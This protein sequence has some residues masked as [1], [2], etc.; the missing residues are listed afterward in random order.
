MNKARDEDAE[1]LIKNDPVRPELS[2]PGS[3]ELSAAFR[4]S[5]AREMYYLG[6]VDQPEAV[7]CIAIC[8][9][10]PTTVAQLEASGEGDIAVIYTVWSYPTAPRAGAQLLVQVWN[11]LRE[12]GTC[13]RY[14][15]LSPKTEMASKLHTQNGAS[16]LANNEETDNFEYLG[17]PMI[18]AGDACPTFTLQ[19]DTGATVELSDLWC[20]GVP[21]DLG[22][23]FFLFPKANI[24]LGLIVALHYRSSASH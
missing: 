15:A 12:K 18:R 23:V 11:M 17:V 2:A 5:G 21:Q 13:A 3:S 6:T 16:L 7:I 24:G 20:S 8:D 19:D 4:T 1:V 14:V 22:V 9:A 10:I